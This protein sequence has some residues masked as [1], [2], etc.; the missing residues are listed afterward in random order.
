MTGAMARRKGATYQRAI[1][2]WFDSHGY[3]T[4]VRQAGEDGDDL[5]ILEHPDLSIEIKNQAR[6][7]LP[8]W[9]AQAA[10]Q[11]GARIPVVIHKRH[12]VTRCE[13]QWVTM[14]L[15]HFHR[16]IERRH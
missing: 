12:G 16:L 8:S 5:T 10:R 3:T 4:M 7:D 2:Q 6:T 11:A 14:T 15:E 9:A 1:R 13:D